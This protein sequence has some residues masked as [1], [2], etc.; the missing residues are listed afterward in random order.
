MKISKPVALLIALLLM[1]SCSQTTV[2]TD[3]DS[4]ANFGSYK[5]YA[6]IE[7][8]IAET[9][10]I[11]TTQQAYALLDEMIKSAA[12]AQLAAKGMTHAAENPDV[13]LIY[14]KGLDQRI[15]VHGWGYTYPGYSYVWWQGTRVDT[16]D[17]RMGTLILDIVDAKTQVL[18][19]RGT[20]T[21]VI[22]EM[23]RPEEREANLKAIMRQLFTKYP[24]K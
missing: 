14:H 15:D 9:G 7:K 23:A 21:K 8:P 20:T 13:L 10:D 5:T 16:Y 3:F 18:V 24:P 19:W 4:R 6:W 1:S 11:K 2:N 22:D 12:D 17:Y